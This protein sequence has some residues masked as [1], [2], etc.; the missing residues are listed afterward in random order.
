MNSIIRKMDIGDDVSVRAADVEIVI[1]IKERITFRP[2]EAEILK[3]SEPI[4]D[5]VANLILRYPSFSVE[6]EGHT[7]N[8]PIRTRLYP[9]NWE[10]SVVRATSVLKYLIATRR[11]DPSR[12]SIKGNADQKPVVPNDTPQERAQNRRVEIR[13]KEKGP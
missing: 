13:M 12:L 5:N 4:L 9:S 3:G 11:I 8:M 1:S 10:L 7:D 2:G 6:I